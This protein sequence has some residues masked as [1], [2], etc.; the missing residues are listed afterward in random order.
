MWPIGSATTGP[1]WSSPTTQPSSPL[2]L[3]PREKQVPPGP[4][5]SRSWLTATQAFGKAHASLPTPL[6]LFTHLQFSAIAG[7]VLHVQLPR[8]PAPSESKLSPVLLSSPGGLHGVNSKCQ[9]RVRSHTSPSPAVPR[10]S[11]QHAQ[12]QAR[13]ALWLPNPAGCSRSSHRTVSPPRP[14]QPCSAPHGPGGAGGW[15][16]EYPHRGVSCCGE[17]LSRWSTGDA[18]I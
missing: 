2:L 1:S 17:A 5:P 6:G 11:T 9:E 18:G 14:A 12:V 4:C 16:A 7:L 3:W 10:P 13:T 15:L 8:P